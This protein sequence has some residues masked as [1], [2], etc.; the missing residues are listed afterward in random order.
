MLHPSLYSSGYYWHSIP[1]VVLAVG[2]SSVEGLRR[3]WGDLACQDG[4]EGA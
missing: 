1:A 3:G 2:I 4:N